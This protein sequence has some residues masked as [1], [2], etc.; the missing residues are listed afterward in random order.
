MTSVRSHWFGIAAVVLATGLFIVSDSML[1][2][3]AQALQQPFQVLFMRCFFGFICSAVFVL[4]MGQWR[5]ISGAFHWRVLLRASSEAASTLFYMAALANMPIADAIAIGQTAPLLVIIAVAV[6]F[7]ERI[8]AIRLVLVC[9]GFLGAVLVAQPTGAGLS[10]AAVYAFLTAMT[11]AMRD[12]L[13]R[14]VPSS[15]PTFVVLSA[16]GLILSLTTGAAALA[17]HPWMPPSP[18]QWLTMIASGFIV[19]LGQMAIFLA[20]R[21]APASVVAPYYYSFTVWAVTAGFVVWRE[22]PNSLAVI[23][24]VLIVGSGIA[25]L[26]VR[27][28]QVQEAV[29]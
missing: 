16:S 9:A 28:R 10:P 12:L 25:L 8:G 18:A 15:I 13:T 4:V 29:A 7:R 23:G 3:T 24:M 20:Y 1:K 27:S 5:E 21:R 14:G 11:V 19:T 26:F 17:L 22:V 2:L 6:I